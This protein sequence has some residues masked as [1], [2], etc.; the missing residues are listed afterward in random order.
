MSWGK[1]REG[2]GLGGRMK[3]KVKRIEGRGGEE[4]AGSSEFLLVGTR[5]E[6]LTGRRDSVAFSLMS[7]DVSGAAFV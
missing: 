3:R 7:G 5:G 1:A 2:P 4:L 6:E